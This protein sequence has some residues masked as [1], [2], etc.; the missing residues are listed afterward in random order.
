MHEADLHSHIF[1]QNPTLAGQEHVCIVRP[2]GDDAAEISWNGPSG[3]VVSTDQLIDR[4][5]VDLRLVSIEDAAIKAIRRSVSDLAAM[6]AMPLASVATAAIPAGGLDDLCGPDALTRLADTL[7]TEALHWRIPLVGG[8]VAWYAA[9]DHPLLLTVT[10]FGLPPRGGTVGRNG[11]RP[12]DVLVVSGALGGTLGADGKGHHL[13]FT[14]RIELATALR[15][16]LGDHLHAMMDLSD[17]LG[18]DASRMGVASNVMLEIQTE[19]I[20]CR[21]VADWKGATGDGEDYELLFTVDEVA[22][23]DLPKTCEGV[24]LTVIGVA[25]S[26]GDAAPGAVLIDNNGD[27]HDAARFGFVHGRDRG[28]DTDPTT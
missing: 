12:G 17:G 15:R 22:A 10:V 24:P 6:A 13:D 5:H 2:P 4:R 23:R 9:G 7:R 18:R 14:P 20:P 3:M 28:D 8:D 26:S 21:G 25:R 16:M 11:A 27:S 19:G 1:Q